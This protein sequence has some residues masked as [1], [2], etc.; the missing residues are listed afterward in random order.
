MDEI[1]FSPP[2]PRHVS[3]H[4]WPRPFGRLRDNRRMSASRLLR[5]RADPARSRC[6]GSRVEKATTIRAAA[7]ERIQPT[8]GWTPSTSGRRKPSARAAGPRDRPMKQ[9]RIA[10]WSD[11][12]HETC[13]AAVRPWERLRLRRHAQNRRHR[14]TAGAPSKEEGAESPG[15][16]Q[17]SAGPAGRLSIRSERGDPGRPRAMAL[18]R[19]S[20]T[21]RPVAPAPR[22]ARPAAARGDSVNSGQGDPSDRPPRNKRNT[23]HARPI[24]SIGNPQ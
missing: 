23:A 13:R 12:A 11:A 1:T 24:P 14:G 22:P 3:I 7:R 21:G 18:P 9:R 20:R 17:S 8:K 19:R 6:A 10:R 16:R 2:F 15:S 5:G 4:R